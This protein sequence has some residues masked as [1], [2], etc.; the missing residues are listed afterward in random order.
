MQKLNIDNHLVGDSII[1]TLNKKIYFFS[2]V[3]YSSFIVGNMITI[4]N[5]HVPLTLKFIKLIKI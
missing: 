3:S 5:L 4:R 2:M 1:K